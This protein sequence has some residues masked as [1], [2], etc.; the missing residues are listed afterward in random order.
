MV[1]VIKTKPEATQEYEGKGE[2]FL[3]KGKKGQYKIKNRTYMAL[4]I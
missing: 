4:D 3:K 1:A 2:I